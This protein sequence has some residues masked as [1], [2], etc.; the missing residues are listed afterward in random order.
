MD[1]GKGCFKIAPRTLREGFSQQAPGLV[2][3]TE[4]GGD[5]SPKSNCLSATALQPV[6]YVLRLLSATR[7]FGV[8]CRVELVGVS[9]KEG[10]VT[11]S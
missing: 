2:V 3:R 11:G 5:G 7:A 1:E 10:G 4:R 8:D 9:L 6:F